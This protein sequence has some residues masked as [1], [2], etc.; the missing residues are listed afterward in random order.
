V[1]WKRRGVEDDMVDEITKKNMEEIIRIVSDFP[2]GCKFTDVLAQSMIDRN[3][4]QLLLSGMVAG[5]RLLRRTSGT[6]I[7]YFK[8]LKTQPLFDEYVILCA[9]DGCHCEKDMQIC[10]Q[11]GE[12]KWRRSTLHKGY[13]SNWN[14]RY[15]ET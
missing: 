10:P 15:E 11:C 8:K 3:S 5:G 1:E 14:C 6:E 12:K 13:C 9:V 2:E 7:T 4:L